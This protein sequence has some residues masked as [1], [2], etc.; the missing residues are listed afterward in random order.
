MPQRENTQ[1]AQP[2]AATAN[3]AQRRQDEKMARERQIDCATERRWAE[4]Q[5]EPELLDR[6][7]DRAEDIAANLSCPDEFRPP[8]A[9][10]A[11]SF[12]REEIEA[13][14]LSHPAVAV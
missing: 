4:L 6:Y 3:S 11:K 5:A 7:F 14:I 8:I 10:I 1:P 9:S 13:E 12:L 2:T